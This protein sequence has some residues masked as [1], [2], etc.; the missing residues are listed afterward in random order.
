[1]V[2]VLISVVG[3]VVGLSVVWVRVM[4]DRYVTGVPSLVVAMV[5]I[6]VVGMVVGLSVVWVRVIVERYVVGVP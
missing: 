6:S 3:M 5:L 1:M 2:T 4:V